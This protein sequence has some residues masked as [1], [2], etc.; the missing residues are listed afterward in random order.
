MSR[1]DV[2]A[3]V[4]GRL[5]SLPPL[6]LYVH[7]PW[8]VRKCPYCDFN[9]HNDPSGGAPFRRYVDALLADLEHALPEV[10]GRPVQT[11]FFGGG[12]PSLMPPDE[13]DRLLA[14]LRARL[15]IAPGAE[16]TL[17]ANPGTVETA[18]LREFAQAGVNRV[19]IGVQS[20]DDDALARIGRIHS[21]ADAHRALEAAAAIFPTWNLDLMF[22]LPGQDL[23][24]LERD[25]T[26]ALAHS[27]PHLSAYHLTLEPN[28]LFAARPP[29][30]L[31]DDDL[32]ADMQDRVVE[33]LARAGLV[34]YEVSAYA[35]DQHRCAHNLNYWR[36]GDY[37]GIG[38]GAHGK[39]SRHDG[40]SRMQRL[41][42]PERFMQAAEAGDAVE[43]RRALEADDLG[44]EFMLNAL[45][46]VDGVPASTFGERTGLSLARLARPI[47][48]AVDLDLLDSDPSTL[49]PTERGLRFL[50]E[51]QALFLGDAPR[52]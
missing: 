39:V 19:S 42:H 37:L 48:R 40:V 32:G 10:W 27:P 23:P 16:I 12:T 34:R 15:R 33:R 30:G 13:L 28:T 49:R 9:S 52:Q 4:G 45:R 51:L 8:C 50:N 17:E 38:A 11:V 24:A 6:S 2:D 3:L 18:R 5:Q 41:R 43:A 44:F 36:F 7:I 21:V 46:L 26:A 22:A 47:A 20:F 14:G 35:R 1:V 31:P 25:L 29:V